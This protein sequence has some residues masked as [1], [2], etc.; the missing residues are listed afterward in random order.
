MEE[1]VGTYPNQPVL[2]LKLL[3]RRLVVVDETEPGAP[4]TTECRPEAEGHNPC[5]VRLVDLGKALREL[6]L[7]DVGAVG[8]ED[9][10]DELAARQQAVGDEFTSADRNRCGVV[11]LHVA[12]AEVEEEREG[13]G[14]SDNPTS[15]RTKPPGTSTC[16]T[17]HPA[18]SNLHSAIPAPPMLCVI[19]SGMTEIHSPCWVPAFV[20]FY[21]DVVGPWRIACTAAR[22]TTKHGNTPIA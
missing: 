11:G 10:H 2:G 21:L 17:I 3:L 13:R 9:I 4:S 1:A 6:V 18:F 20:S 15:Q 22:I 16:Q 19:S 7:G 5:L 8:V 12:C 14:S